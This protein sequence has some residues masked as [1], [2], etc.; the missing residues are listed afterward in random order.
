VCGSI[1]KYTNS[2]SIS[3]EAVLN[4]DSYPYTFTLYVGCKDNGDKGMFTLEM[5]CNDKDFEV[6]D[7]KDF[8]RA[9][10]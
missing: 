10:F 1:I 4:A 7:D 2:V 6:I 5:N 8:D 3:N 9:G